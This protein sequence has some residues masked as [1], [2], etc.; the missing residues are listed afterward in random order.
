MGSGLFH[1]LNIGEQ[2]LYNTRQGVDTASHNISNANTVGYSRQRVNLKT[3]EPQLLGGVLAG[4][5]SYIENIT[6]THNKFVERQLNRAQHI[7]GEATGRFEALKSLESIFSPELASAVPDEITNFFNSLQE[8]SVTPSDE[9]IR[10]AVRESAKN[11]T[12]AF[13]RVDGDIKQRRVDLNDMIVQECAEINSRLYGIRQLNVQIQDAESTPGAVAND[14]RDQRDLLLRELTEKIQINYYEDD[15]GNFCLRGPDDTLL[16]DKTSVC[17]VT[18]SSSGSN[19]GFVDVVVRDPANG[20]T[21]NITRKME[22]GRIKGLIEVRD[23]VCSDLLNKNNEMAANFV[24]RVNEIH[25]KGYGARDYEEF[26]GRGFFKP[27]SDIRTAAGAMDI[28]DEILSTVD[29]IS[30]AG[31]PF[32]VGDNIVAN[33]LLALKNEKF[34]DDGKSTL[35]EFYANYVGNLGIEINRTEHSKDAN[36]IVVS[37][38]QAQ[39]EASSGVS[40]DEEAINLMKWQS[41]FTASSKVITTVDEMLETVLSLKR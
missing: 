23:N 8:L 15:A 34:L 25:S 32:A 28:S 24:G 1:T 20:F 41:N 19:E 14:L 37:D 39:R 35:V 2:S 11:V 33:E 6:R 18:G 9:S 10:A 3:R 27:V 21:R 17:E 36:D 4:S 26:S 31:T 22:G 16:L 5:G 30:A 29:A 12:S 40:L 7:S 38:L 13:K